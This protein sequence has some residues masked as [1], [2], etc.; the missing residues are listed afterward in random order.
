MPRRDAA[1][2]IEFEAQLGHHVVRHHQ[3]LPPIWFKRLL[4]SPWKEPSYEMP[5]LEDEESETEKSDFRWNA[6]WYCVA[7]PEDLDKNVPTPLTVLGIPMVLWFDRTQ[8]KWTCFLDQCPHRLAPLS[9]GRID[10]NG[11]LQCSYHGWSFKGD[12]G[13]TC[14]PQASTEGPE[15]RAAASDRARV[16]SFSVREVHD[17]LF[18]WPDAKGAEEAERTP[19]PLLDELYAEGITRS[20]VVRDL[21]YGFDVLAENIT[22]PSHLPFAHHG[23]GGLRRKQGKPLPLTLQSKGADGFTGVSGGYVFSDS[24]QSTVEFK[25]P[26]RFHYHRVLEKDGKS[27]ESFTCLYMTP[28]VPGKSRLVLIDAFGVKLPWYFKYLRPRWLAHLQS[29]DILDGDAS[30]LHWQQVQYANTGA[31][32]KEFNKVYFMPTASD[33]FVIGFRQWL[34]KFGHGGVQYAAGVDPKIPLAVLPKEKVLNRYEGHT[35][36]C[37]TCQEAL[38]QIE[39]LR[40]GLVVA[41]VLLTASAAVLSSPDW[42]YARVGL[43][44]VALTASG[45]AWKLGDVVQLFLF[46]GY[47][48]HEVGPEKPPMVF[49]KV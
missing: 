10:E 33:R 6:N 19:V 16:T 31:S 47:N 30:F 24:M 45:A 3:S 4:Y 2:Q 44:T 25:A 1:R 41:A 28:T 26:G 9:E 36:H 34:S 42:L 20:S 39:A 14:I 32:A 49:S 27:R 17:L 40:V 22:D 46:R 29:Q 23:V 11:H 38:R 12:G 21:E 15:S 5:E 48:H 7:L 35:K 37:K 13:C 18:V 8:D 43:L